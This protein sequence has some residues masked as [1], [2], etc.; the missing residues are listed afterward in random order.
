MIKG[1]NGL[2]V[3][4]FES[5]RSKE[6]EKLI[7]YH[8][9]TPRVAPSMKEIPLDTLNIS[10]FKTDIFSG[11]TDVLILMTGVGTRMLTEL[12]K[13]EF[14]LEQ[15]KGALKSTKIIARGPKPVAALKE[16]DIVPDITI[17][18]PNTWKDIVSTLDETTDIRG[19]NIYVQEYGV[20]NEQFL[21]ALAERGANVK[22]VS[23]Y[24]W[25]LPDD[26]QPLKEAI[27]S[28]TQGG[29][30]LVLFTSSQQV[31]NMF[32]VASKE[33]L[34]SKLYDSFGNTVI[35]S[36]G[37]TTSETLKNFN[38]SVDYEPD[39]PKMGNLIRE[40]ARVSREL[41]LKKRT[42]LQSGI[43]TVNWKR[44]DMFWENRGDKE[45]TSQFVK[46]CRLEKTDYT[47]IWIMRQAGRFLR[48]YREIRSK[49][50]FIELCKT[51]EIAADV[52]LMAVEKLNVDAAIIF[53][54][55]LL[56]LQSLGVDL[57]YSKNDGPRIQ[58]VLR[59]PKAVDSL[60]EFEPE[61]MDYVY[62]AIKLVRS[63][64]NPDKALIGFAGAP[65]T[66]ASYAIEGGGSKNY[67]NTKSLMYRDPGLW[68]SLMMKLTNATASYL[69][70]QIKAGADAVQLFDSWVGCL[71]PDDYSEY[72][73]P[74]MKKLVSMIEGEVPVILFGT[75]TATLLGHMTDTGYDVIGVDWRVDIEEAWHSIGYETAIQGNLDPLCLLSTQSYIKN[76][77][78]KI[79][80]KTSGI[81]GHI[82]NLG[83]GV[84]PS[85][86]VDNVLALVDMVHEYSQN[87][88]KDEMQ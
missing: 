4:S 37:P 54:D 6:I 22:T 55:I 69:N 76:E 21:N 19:L 9:G 36:I 58:R 66:V 5:R 64:L 34:K 23:I 49:V 29:E 28:I 65:F 39:S 79:L 8:G 74:H 31:V 77:A 44:T 45:T 43:Q 60:L 2:K 20:T 40:I 71:S 70:Y 3:T 63:S 56:I 30:D 61:S 12:I 51:P 86:P 72:V 50:S 84:L 46:A 18:E 68:N 59:S 88:K 24:R 85:T 14:D 10:N 62:D 35:G 73:L 7:V 48:E 33:G 47:P 52:T 25:G 32:D 87:I 75:D 80:D 67:I 38:I 41:L 1:L 13:T 27:N 16:I 53:S 78:K 81:P 15:Y 57:E 82:F 42:A 26:I 11:K 83:H 17:K